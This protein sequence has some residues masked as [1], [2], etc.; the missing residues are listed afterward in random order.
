MWTPGIIF[1]LF[2]WLHMTFIQNC[3][4]V[5]IPH[6]IQFIGPRFLGLSF[7]IQLSFNLLLLLSN[8][9]PE[10]YL[11]CWVFFCMVKWF[12]R[13][14]WTASPSLCFHYRNISWLSIL[15]RNVGKALKRQNSPTVMR[16][17]YQWN[18][19]DQLKGNKS[20]RLWLCGIINMHEYQESKILGK[21]SLE[22]N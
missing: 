3:F 9:Q 13:P 12:N 15:L 1:P 6:S 5:T 22:C 11:P 19:R 18:A 17:V 21:I 16:I 2:L 14:C 10:S 20:V 8:W 7:P 4:N